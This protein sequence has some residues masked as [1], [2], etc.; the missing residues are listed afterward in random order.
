M[1]PVVWLGAD[2][3]YYR[4]GGGQLWVYLN[5]ALGLHA[6]GSR[7]VWLEAVY[8]NTPTNRLASLPG[9]LERRLGPYRLGG[10]AWPVPPGQCPGGGNL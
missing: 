9:A 4:V 7:V 6:L 2:T 8:P 5:W 3:L 10:R 1:S